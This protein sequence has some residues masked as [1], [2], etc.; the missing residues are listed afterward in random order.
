MNKLWTT[1]CH[2]IINL[3]VNLKIFPEFTLSAMIFQDIFLSFPGFPWL[4]KFS[5]FF[6]ESDVSPVHLNPLLFDNSKYHTYHCLS[7]MIEKWKEV[8]RRG[9]FGGN[10]LTDISGYE[11]PPPPPPPIKSIL[12]F[13][14]C[15]KVQTARLLY[16]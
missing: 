16:C 15:L 14:P 11:S 6:P 4:F 9:V 7:A 13:M 3:N 1:Q 5:K 2:T 8:L 10:I 12:V